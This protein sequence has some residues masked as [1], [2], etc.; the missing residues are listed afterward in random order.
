[1]NCNRMVFAATLLAVVGIGGWADGRIEA[2]Q[3]VRAGVSQPSRAFRNVRI[4]G[5]IVRFEMD[6]FRNLMPP[7]DE[8]SSGIVTSVGASTTDPR[9]LPSNLQLRSVRLL[10]GRRTWQG[11]LSRLGVADQPGFITRRAIG[12]PAWAPGSRANA[13]VEYTLGHRTYRVGLL[14]ATVTAAY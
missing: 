9:G 5:R 1:M 13:I 12:G 4:A 10:Q 8:A 7:V 2:G 14:N 6:L 11:P 3:E